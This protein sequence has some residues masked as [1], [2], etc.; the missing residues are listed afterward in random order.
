MPVIQPQFD[1]Q[2]SPPAGTELRFNEYGSGGIQT[3]NAQPRLQLFPVA[4]TQPKSCSIVEQYVEFAIL[5][6]L[7]TTDPIEFDDGR[8]VNAAKDALIQLLIEFRQAAT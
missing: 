6:E 3:A 8:T 1:E 5:V 4:P 7:Q 2:G